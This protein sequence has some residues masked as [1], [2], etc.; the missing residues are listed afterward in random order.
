M[1]TLRSVAEWTSLLS[2]PAGSIRVQLDDIYGG[3]AAITDKR[4]LLWTDALE[5][6]ARNYSPNARV[7]MA[8]STG[9]VNLLGMH[10][11]HRGGAVNALAVGDTIFVV[12]PRDDDL[13]VLRNADPQFPAGQ[14]RIRDELPPGGVDD[15]DKWTIRQY[16]RRLDAGTQA[17]WS[18][19]VRAGVLYLQHLNTAPNG[20][21]RPALRGMDV[22]V[23]GNVPLRS[24]LSSSSSIVVGGMEAC[25]H[26]NGIK[27]SDKE[28]VDAA[29]VAEWYVGTRGGGGDH[30]AIKFCRHGQLAHLGAFPLT[31]KMIPFPEDYCVVLCDSLVETAKTA[32][33]RNLFNQRVACYELGML[34]LRK[35]FPQYTA[36][37]LRLRDVNPDSLGTDEGAIYQMLKALPEL[38]H[39]EELSAALTDQ[40]REL[41]RIYRTHEPVPDGYRVRAACLYGI[42]EC[43]RSERALELLPAGDVEG[44]GELITISH[45]GDRITRMVDGVRC[46]LTKPLPDAELDRLAADVR[47][48]DPARRRKARIYR[49]PGGYDASCPELD[50]IVDIVLDVPGVLGAGLVGAGLGGSVAVMGKKDRT[51]ADIATVEEHY[52]RPRSLPV[53]TQICTGVGGSGVFKRGVRQERGLNHRRQGPNPA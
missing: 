10:I 16:Q 9:R 3:D 50:E 2:D 33:S 47:S 1:D 41:E 20:R 5:G 36:K 30:A 51:D 26:V 49:Q 48:T 21:F 23:N 7:F 29:H 37:M 15:W 14:F 12:A 45:D 24:G 39:R 35:S 25:I 27:M 46:P 18:N 52:Y 42:A 43:L 13:V 31:V 44:F 38:A 8:R 34:I 22:F 4:L 19:Y 28:L 40:P 32:G 17:D 11:D 6:Y 53:T